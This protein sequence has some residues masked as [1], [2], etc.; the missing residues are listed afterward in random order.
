MDGTA[1]RDRWHVGVAGRRADWVRAA[2]GGVVDEPC[3]VFGDHPIGGDVVKGGWFGAVWP[4]VR[5]D[6][7]AGAADDRVWGDDSTA[8]VA[9]IGCKCVEEG[10]EQYGGGVRYG[11]TF[12]EGRGTCGRG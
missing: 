2:E 12:G 5:L 11:A 1:H 10:V 4:M 3:H 6:F 9:H 8:E 7:G